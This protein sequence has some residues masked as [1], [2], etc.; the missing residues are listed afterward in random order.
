[1]VFFHKGAK[2]FWKLKSSII[3][4]ADKDRF[5]IQQLDT[6]TPETSE[7]QTF[8]SLILN[9]FCIWILHLLVQTIF[10]DSNIF[11]YIKWCIL[12][13]RQ[14]SQLGTPCEYCPGIQMPFRKWTISQTDMLQPFEYLVINWFERYKWLL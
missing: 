8:S 12:V 9:D 14:I 4:V 10:I 2:S 3:W 11:G 5:K 13:L 6:L 7:N 1:M